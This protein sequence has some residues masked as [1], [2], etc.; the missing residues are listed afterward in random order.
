V[1]RHKRFIG[2][3]ISIALLGS[4]VA[5]GAALPPPGTFVDDNGNLHEANIE[6]IAAAGITS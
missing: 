4:A 5:A 3:A 6:A 2:I 1:R